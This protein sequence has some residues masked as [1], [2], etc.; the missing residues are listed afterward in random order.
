VRSVLGPIGGHAFSALVILNAIG[1]FA[2]Y[3][4][5]LQDAASQVKTGEEWLDNFIQF[6][7]LITVLL[8]CFAENAWDIP[9][10]NDIAN[11]ALI[12]LIGGIGWLL[13]S[14]PLDHT[15]D[16]PVIVAAYPHTSVLGLL[17]ASTISIFA[18]SSA[19]IIL[20]MK[21]EHMDSSKVLFAGGLS[22][23]ISFLLYVIVGVLGCY[24]PGITSHE[25]VLTAFIGQGVIGWIILFVNFL[26]IALSIPVFI[27]TARQYC[28][29][30]MT[31]A[32]SKGLTLGPSVTRWVMTALL[33]V[34][35]ALFKQLSSH[36]SVLIEF[37]SGITDGLFMMVFPP[38]VSLYHFR[39]DMTPPVQCACY[40]LLIYGITQ[41][42]M[43]LSVALSG[44][45]EAS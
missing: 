31:L 40:V 45:I 38:L 7:L 18:F 37:V 2:T 14:S 22:L 36:L 24:L 13:F 15:S 5:I 39:S 23:V 17:K 32:P 3:F 20:F 21:S 33:I 25:S 11:G 10:A 1:V 35:A 30:L 44:D 12:I 26:S 42:A 4:E 16:I 9:W 34:F 28:R 41:F 29:H 43:T 8:G 27:I 6:S 19:E